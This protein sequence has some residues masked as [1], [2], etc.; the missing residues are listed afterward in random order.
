MHP[1]LFLALIHPLIHELWA[2]KEKKKKENP[3]SYDEMTFFVGA[4]PFI[5]QK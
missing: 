1:S 2:H 5:F 4:V 3:F